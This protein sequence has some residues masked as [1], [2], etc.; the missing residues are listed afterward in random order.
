MPIERT[1][2]EMEQEDIQQRD[3]AYQGRI[4]GNN[5]KGTMI[6]AFE[7]QHMLMPMEVSEHDHFSRINTIHDYIDMLPGDGD[8]NLTEQQRKRMSF[9]T[10]H[11]R[12]WQDVYIDTAVNFRKDADSGKDSDE[13]L[14][15]EDDE[16]VD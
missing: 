7:H 15:K 3:R 5:A 10:Q 8:N 4:Q 16:T 14:D 13:D 6:A 1:Q 9:M 12:S 2:N 11:P